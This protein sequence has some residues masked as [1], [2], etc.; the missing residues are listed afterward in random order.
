MVAWKTVRTRPRK[1]RR[2]LTVVCIAALL[3]C[4]S[5][6]A[7]GTRGAPT[8]ASA[9]PSI[10]EATV[11]AMSHALLDAY[12]RADEDRAGVAL[13]PAFVL[14]DELRREP[15]DSVL[16]RLH[17]RLA[18][19]APP[20]TRTYG[21]EHTWIADNSAVFVAETVEHYPR[22]GAL[23]CEDGSCMTGD[24]DG[25][26]T[27]VWVRDGNAWKVASWQWVKGGL[28]ADRDEWNAVYREGK[29]FNPAPNKF[30]VEMVKGRKPGLALDVAMGQGRNALYLASQGW[31]VTGIDI[32][33]EGI[34]QAREAAAARK[35]TLEAINADADT[36]DFGVEKWD[37]VVMIYAGADD[38]VVKKSLKRGGLVV[39]ERAHKELNPRIGVE[40]DVFS[41][42]YTDGFT[43]LR[44]DV[45]EDVS[46]W[47][48]RERTRGKVVRFAAEKQ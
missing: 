8:D 5:A 25:W 28:E 44:N 35:L 26:S 36:W 17:K 2:R 12:D 23:P 37:L 22:D 6:P 9:G 10:D 15:R 14:L 4:R 43:I 7:D 29:D 16:A 24:F 30:L 18:R 27:L 33:D 39:S 13:G 45:V 48:W 40:P 3:S 31:R 42:A 47:G 32:S 38:S 11:K 1:P 46:D 21:E 34:R 19:H 41:A 20:R